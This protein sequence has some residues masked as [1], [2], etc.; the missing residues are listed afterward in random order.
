MTAEKEKQKETREAWLVGRRLDFGPD[1]ATNPCDHR[2]VSVPQFTQIIGAG[3][4]SVLTQHLEQW[5]EAGGINLNGMGLF[6]V[7][8]VPRRCKACKG[9]GGL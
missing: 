7:S 3:I 4:V 1:F 2:Q 5:V 9:V 6:L 8:K